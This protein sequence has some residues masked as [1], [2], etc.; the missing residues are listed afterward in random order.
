M[1]EAYFNGCPVEMKGLGT[2]FL[3]IISSFNMLSSVEYANNPPISTVSTKLL[4]EIHQI[5]CPQLS[6]TYYM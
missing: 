2:P 6:S 1:I 4:L 5:F 3:D